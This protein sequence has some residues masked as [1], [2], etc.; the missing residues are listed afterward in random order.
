MNT[1]IYTYIKTIKIKRLA[2]N[3]YLRFSI[4]GLLQEIHE[5]ICS[6][7]YFFLKMNEQNSYM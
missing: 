7:K 4:Y 6:T 5:S 1:M 3:V 2:Y